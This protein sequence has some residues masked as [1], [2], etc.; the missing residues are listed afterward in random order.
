MKSTQA[1]TTVDAS[2]AGFRKS[3]KHGLQK[4]MIRLAGDWALLAN[5][6]TKAK[7]QE[8]AKDESAFFDAF[9]I[10]WGK[11][12]G[13]SH[14]KLKPCSG[15]VEKTEVDQAVDI[16]KC[17]D[18]HWKCRRANKCH[19][20]AWAAQCPRKCGKCPDQEGSR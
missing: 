3:G 13:K 18:R 16:L 8:F 9:A 19:N 15:S 11:V 10:A 6:E 20:A 5:P 1:W 14:S 2:W 7:V 4:R 12:I 17:Q